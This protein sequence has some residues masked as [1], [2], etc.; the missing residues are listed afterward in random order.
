MARKPPPLAFMV[1]ASVFA[2]G[3]S[4]AHSLYTRGPRNTLIFLVLGV[5]MSAV[6]EHV[7][8]NVLKL[9][10]HHTGPQ[11]KGLP[12]SMIFG[13]YN[14]IYATYALLESW[15]IRQGLEEGTLLWVLP[16]STM[17]IATSFDL[18]IDCFG[19]DA[20][21]WEWHSD[22]V[23]AAEIT[24]PNGRRGVPLAN[25]ILWLVLGSGISLFYLLLA[26][27]T[28]PGAFS[29]GA[30]GSETALTTAILLLVPYYVLGAGW[31]LFRRRFRYLLYSSPFALALVV[32][33]RS[34]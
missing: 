34:L 20:G 13:W 9:V 10:R 29:G 16:L 12:L 23:Y 4:L 5:G 18:L 6:G 33:L 11:L 31:A 28:G 3:L 8:V 15:W 19:L 25:F 32:A 17:V 14:F 1:S 24:G 7:V 26:R 30:A 22:S 2:T 21:L 27:A